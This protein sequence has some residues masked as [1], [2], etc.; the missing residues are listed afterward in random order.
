[1]EGETGKDLETQGVNSMNSVISLTL[2]RPYSESSNG[3]SN[4]STQS[5]FVQVPINGQIFILESKNSQGDPKDYYLDNNA[6]LRPVASASE[7]PHDFSSE[8]LVQVTNV[9]D[10][11]DFQ[12]LCPEGIVE[13]GETL[14][15]FQGNMPQLDGSK[16]NYTV[17]PMTLSNNV[18]TSD[19]TNDATTIS[20]ESNNNGKDIVPI[21]EDVSESPGTEA[22]PGPQLSPVVNAKHAIDH[23]YLTLPDHENSKT[24]QDNLL[25]SD[26]IEQL[27][28]IYHPALNV[29][30]QKIGH[31]PMLLLGEA[32][33]FVMVRGSEG[34]AK[35]VIGDPISSDGTTS[36]GDNQA[37]STNTILTAE[38]IYRCKKCLQTFP[39]E[40]IATY[41]YKKVH[42]GINDYQCQWC[43]GVFPGCLRVHQELC[44][45]KAD[46]SN[47]CS[48]KKG[49]K[50]TSETN[51]KGIKKR[52]NQTEVP[53]TTNHRHYS[54]IIAWNEGTLKSENT[55]PNKCDHD[56]LY[57][58]AP[59]FILSQS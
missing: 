51:K 49:Q 56:I 14:T 30:A 33:K 57:L 36:G 4:Q 16:N 5:L 28:A 58:T 13:H 7:I 2:E 45:V 37:L 10:N 22:L 20:Y 9:C 23:D 11:Q 15:G 6:C 54:S 17:L 18:V 42:L 8:Q 29:A 46:T 53:L 50:R 1:M 41:H 48:L 59:A 44:T 34:S 47:E 26:A 55:F 3:D 24:E 38:T 25:V 35:N 31:Q 32:G 39:L 12:P 43:L 27:Y 21:G 40:T 19:S 52:L